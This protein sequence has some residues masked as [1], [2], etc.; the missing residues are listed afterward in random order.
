MSLSAR[1]IWRARATDHYAVRHRSTDTSSRPVR[2]NAAS[3]RS[4]ISRSHSSRPTSETFNP[5]LGLC[6]QICAHPIAKSVC[7][8]VTRLRLKNPKTP[9]IYC[10]NSRFRRQCKNAPV[11]LLTGGLLVRIQ[12]EE[13]NFLVCSGDIGNTSFRTH[14]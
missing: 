12:P 2:H 7:F 9:R 6:A 1:L 3:R 5:L 8:S 11:E 10:P 13:P 14:G 4:G